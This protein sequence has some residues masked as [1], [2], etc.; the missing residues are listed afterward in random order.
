MLNSW[1]LSWNTFEVSKFEK[2]LRV[3]LSATFVHSLN[4]FD[5]PEEKSL[6]KVV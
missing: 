5:A 1:Y 4:I 2:Y 6:E 3:R